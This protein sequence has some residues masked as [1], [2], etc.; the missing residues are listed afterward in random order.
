M[1][2][3]CHTIMDMNIHNA[4]GGPKSSAGGTIVNERDVANNAP[5]LGKL[6]F[7]CGGRHTS[8]TVSPGAITK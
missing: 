1:V 7:M 3:L 5:K 8:P 6:L 4:P 2:R